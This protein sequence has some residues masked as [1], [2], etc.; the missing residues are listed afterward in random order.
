MQPL[1]RGM[2]RVQLFPSERGI[3]NILPF[4]N[5]GNVSRLTAP[6]EIEDR[7]PAFIRQFA[8]EAGYWR[9]AHEHQSP[10]HCPAANCDC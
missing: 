1:D 5:H 4:C 3:D 2:T 7:R 8:P 9:S 10:R 6:T